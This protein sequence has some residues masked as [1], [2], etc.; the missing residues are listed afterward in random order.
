MK[1]WEKI[2]TFEDHKQTPT[3]I[4]FNPKLNNSSTLQCC[5]GYSDGSLFLINYIND[6]WSFVSQKAHIFSVN[7]ISWLNTS[8]SNTSKILTG[9]N[10]GLIKLWNINQ[11]GKIEK[12]QDLFKAHESPIKSIEMIYS[13]E[14]SNSHRQ[15]N[16]LSLDVDDNMFLWY[17][18]ITSGN[19]EFKIEEIKFNETQIPTG[20]IHVSYKEQYCI[21]VSTQES[22]FLYKQID[23]EWVIF[24][25][26]NGEGLIANYE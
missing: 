2:F 26:T 9:G 10:D 25:S 22:T 11:N 3:C 15:N 21:S 1:D 17:S 13:I 16:F 5:V 6:V 19:M 8:N 18:D 24:S 20:I 12:V 7:T 4:A 14:E 23:K